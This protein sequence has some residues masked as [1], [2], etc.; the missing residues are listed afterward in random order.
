MWYFI[1]HQPDLNT[2]QF[3][4]FRQAAA[5]TEAEPF[6]EPFDNLYIFAVER[7]QYSA[8]ADAL[9]REGVVYQATTSKPTR[10]ELLAGLKEIMQ[11]K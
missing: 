9:D 11:R 7:D 5:F 4:E 1:I 2:A 8:F 10:E 3:Q 6:N